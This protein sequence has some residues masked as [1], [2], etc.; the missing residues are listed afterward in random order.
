MEIYSVKDSDLVT[1]EL[2]WVR[3]ESGKYG[4]K[5]L[6]FKAYRSGSKWH[7][8]R[9]G[10]TVPRSRGMVQSFPSLKEACSTATWFL[11]E[12]LRQEIVSSRLEEW[13]HQNPQIASEWERNQQ[14]VNFDWEKFKSGNYLSRNHPYRVFRSN[15]MWRLEI[16]GNLVDR[17]FATRQLA[18]SE[19]RL[20][21][22]NLESLN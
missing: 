10:Q 3:F 22:I 9:N 20:S 12:E 1:I 11:R 5:D 17:V 7:L 13:R 2:D 14:H 4:T 8:E 19:A 18:Y 6:Q 21:F 16:D 15:G